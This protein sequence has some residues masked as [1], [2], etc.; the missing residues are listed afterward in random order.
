M[1]HI[2]INTKQAK[3]LN[4]AAEV[5]FTALEYRLLLVFANH[6]GQVLSRNQLLEGIWDIEGNF[7]ND[8]TLSVY[9][10]RLREKLSDGG[11]DSLIETVRGLGYRMNPAARND[12]ETDEK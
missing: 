7:I 2:T 9:I 6:L 8:N 3:V 10:K 12:G 4:G 11:S 1:G 5:P